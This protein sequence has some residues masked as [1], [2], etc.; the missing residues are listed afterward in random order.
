MRDNINHQRRTTPDKGTLAGPVLEPQNS[1]VYKAIHGDHDLQ[2][3]DTRLGDF[4]KR[5]NVGALTHGPDFE[6]RQG[7]TGWIPLGQPAWCLVLL[8]AMNFSAMSRIL[9]LRQAGK[10]T[11]RPL[12]TENWL[13]TA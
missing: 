7:D 10:Q 5:N 11:T 6:P 12:S 9:V 3:N 1:T 4:G 8:L 2:T 13:I